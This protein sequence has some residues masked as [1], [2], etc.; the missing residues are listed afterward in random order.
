MDDSQSPPSAAGSASVRTGPPGEGGAAEGRRSSRGAPALLASLRPRQWVKNLF[1]LAPVLFAGRLLEPDS[2]L[3]ALAAF[4]LFTAA[5]GAVYLFNDLVDLE[6]DR[7][8]PEK[9]FRPL[10]A[11]RL[12]PATA[13]VAGV[14]LGAGALLGGMVLA[15]GF[16]WV[17]LAYLILNGAYSL[18]LKHW[19]LV[20]VFVVAL[21]FVFR[22]VA[23]AEAIAVAISPWLLLC[24]F[25]VALFLALGKRRH[26]LV[27]LEDPV[28]HRPILAH[29]STLFIDQMLVVLAAVTIA[30]YA[31]Y[32]VAPRTVEHFGSENLIFTVPFVLFGIFRFLY[33]V[34]QRPE[35]GHPHEVML[36]DPPLL[37]TVLAW[38]VAAAA[39]I[40]L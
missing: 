13:V 28:A 16:A 11:G 22:A 6:Q 38:G 39:V 7:L 9:R 8:H 21:G 27:T 19:V 2:L 35:A 23:G 29:Y 26:E 37:L 40:Y 5:S 31:L 25:F 34:Y 30:A 20:D 18:L 24:T 10:A 1:V 12:R 32:T 15:P 3:R 33:L 17:V 4:G 36:T 14:V